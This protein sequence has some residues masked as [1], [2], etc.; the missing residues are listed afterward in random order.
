[1]RKLLT[2]VHVRYSFTTPQPFPLFPER[3]NSSRVIRKSFKFATQIDHIPHQQRL[4]IVHHRCRRP[5]APAQPGQILPVAG[6]GRCA[7]SPKIT[8]RK[9]CNENAKYTLPI[10][11]IAT[12]HGQTIEKSAPRYRTACEK[13]TKCGVGLTIRMTCW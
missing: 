5:D 8:R 4:A 13:A 10:A 9:R 3:S 6:I 11:A 2:I 12:S 1:D 7:Q